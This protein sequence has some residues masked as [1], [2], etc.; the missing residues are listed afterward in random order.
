MDKRLYT[1]YFV[2]CSVNS[3]Y[4]SVIPFYPIV[5]H[6]KGVNFIVIGAI[7]AVM[8]VVTFFASLVL[9]TWLETI[10]RRAALL[11][12]IVLAVRTKQG[13]SLL[14]VSASLEFE[15]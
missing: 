12:G 8:S 15:M 4:C 9:G 2:N 3:I 6:A 10:G 1:I 11:S 13:T 5:A 14:V 7:V